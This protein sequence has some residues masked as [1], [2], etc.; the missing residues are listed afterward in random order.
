MHQACFRLMHYFLSL[1]YV[2]ISSSLQSKIAQRVSKVKFR[3]L[4]I[5]YKD[6]LA[7]IA[8]QIMGSGSDAQIRRAIKTIEKGV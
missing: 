1:T 8:E 4:S 2:A 6:G 3:K 7:Y 5:Q